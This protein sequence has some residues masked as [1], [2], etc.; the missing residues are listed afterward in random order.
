MDQPAGQDRVLQVQ[1][2]DD[3]YDVS[4]E[5]RPLPLILAKNAHIDNPYEFGSP[6]RGPRKFIVVSQAKLRGSVTGPPIPIL[7]GLYYRPCR[8]QAFQNRY[9]G[10]VIEPQKQAVV[11]CQGLPA[12][13]T[14]RR[15]A[16]AGSFAYSFKMARFK[17]E[18]TDQRRLNARILFGHSLAFCM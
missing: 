2:E 11:P 7:E 1:H 14:D 5:L 9:G 13:G 6:I 12:A 4:D 18:E 8:L 10:P 16:S 15:E 3:F 17:N